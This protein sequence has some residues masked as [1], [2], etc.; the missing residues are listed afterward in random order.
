MALFLCRWPNGDCSVVLARDETE[1]IERLD[2]VA[3]AEGC[4][5]TELENLQIHFALTDE[6]R[7][8]LERVGET[9]E[10]VWLFQ[11]EPGELDHDGVR[12]D[13][14]V[15][16]VR[17]GAGEPTSWFVLNGR[18]LIY[19]DEALVQSPIGTTFMNHR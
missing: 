13:A 3:N 9:T 10:D 14:G 5:I 2:E 11:G 16:F 4:P 6:G 12:T 7:L 8:A 18:Q 1:A 15:A 17:T 19:R